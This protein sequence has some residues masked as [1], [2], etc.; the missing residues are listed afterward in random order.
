MIEVEVKAR[1]KDVNTIKKR[2]NRI[3]AKFLKK[4]KQT[5]RIFGNDMFLDEEH[6][7]IE[8]GILA[9]IRIVNNQKILEFKEV[10]RHSGGLEIK[11]ELKDINMGLNLLRKLK[12]N[13]AFAVSKLREKYS[14]KDMTICLDSV[15][16]L[17][18]FIEIEKMI[19]S[20]DG[21]ETARRECID[22]LNILA[23]DSEI[24]SRK[25]G[26]M[27]QESINKKNS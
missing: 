18:R 17:G 16:G 14:H 8:G 15:I 6:K 1:T 11:S 4:E 12:F 26:D 13:E 25:Y 9:R 7:I 10:A 24:E 22:L 2:L 3:G 27:I 23:P 19:D 5:D 21:K 20:E